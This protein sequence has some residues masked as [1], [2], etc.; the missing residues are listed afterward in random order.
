MG[1]FGG[2]RGSGE[3]EQEDPRFGMV[4]CCVVQYGR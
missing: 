2:G 1:G 3:L 4:T